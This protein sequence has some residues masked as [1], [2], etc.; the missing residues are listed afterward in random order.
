MSRPLSSATVAAVGFTCK[1]FLNLGFASVTVNGLPT[2]AAALDH[3]NRTN[4]QGVVTG[5]YYHQNTAPYFA[6]YITVSNH[7]ST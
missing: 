2:L 6:D 5:G 4:G 7:I 1:A 3:S